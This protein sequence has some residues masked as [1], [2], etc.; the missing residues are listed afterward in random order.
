MPKEV[1][2]GRRVYYYPTPS[3]REAMG[4]Q[5]GISP[6]DA[7]VLFVHNQA[8]EIDGVVQPSRVTLEV[9]SHQGRKETLYLTN[10]IEDREPTAEEAAAGGYCMWMPY[11]VA[12]HAEEA[13]PSA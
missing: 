4:A 11:Q 1:T 9:T 5:D 13:A 8:A 6:F 7:G 12:K 3:E 10:L 2:I